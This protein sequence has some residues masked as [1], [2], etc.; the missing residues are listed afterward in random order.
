MKWVS[1]ISVFAL[2]AV[3]LTIDAAGNLPTFEGPGVTLDE[4]FN[5]DVGWFIVQAEWTYGL[6]ALVPA[7]QAEIFGIDRYNPDHPPL[8]RVCLGISDSLVRT[9]I[10][11]TAT[12]QARWLVS[13][14]RPAAAVAFALT[15]FLV[16]SMTW[17]WTSGS[18]LAASVAAIA[19]ATT[20]RVF[21]H[22][23]IASLESF[24]G[25][26]FAACVFWLA[27]RT[28]AD[29]SPRTA[30]I[31][32][33]L[34]GLALLTKIQAVLIPIPFAIWGLWHFRHK[35]IIPGAVFGIAGFVTFFVGWPWLWIDPVNHVLEY[36]GA[37]LRP[38]LPQ[39]LL[40]GIRLQ[41]PHSPDHLHVDKLL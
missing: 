9:A 21:G 7:S 33:I 4:S 38:P 8:G 16:G 13:S 31:G 24:I 39:R 25:L 36:F 19:F 26:T 2:V 28:A 35:A 34:W 18:A 6:A 29:L 15:V 32:G 3:L 27:D 17:R 11:H 1:G 22:A 20:P 41:R 37:W 14:A 5:I 10:P 23:H 12:P 30:A 40:R